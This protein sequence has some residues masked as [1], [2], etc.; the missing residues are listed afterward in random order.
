[1][2][3][4]KKTGMKKEMDTILQNQKTILKNQNKILGEE[5]KIE[6]MERKELAKED[7]FEKT[8][9]ETLK[10]LEQ[11]E[12]QIKKDIENPLKKVTYRD[13]TKG[14]VGAFIGIVGHFAFAKGTEIAQTLT[15]LKSTVL[16]IVGFLIIIIMLYTTGFR[17]VEKRIMLKFMPM[18][19]IILFCVSILTIFFVYLMFGKIH[20]PITFLELYNLIGA[21]IILAALGAS[22]ADLIGRSE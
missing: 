10:E 19:A 5:Q 3:T 8:E 21:T 11:L 6:E 14:F 22:T 17:K 12:K 16:Y 7:M 9:E 15:F 18:R 13:L 4:K 1:M 2:K 20:F